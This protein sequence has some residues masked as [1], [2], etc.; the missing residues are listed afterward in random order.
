M[1]FIHLFQVDKNCNNTPQD[2]EGA[3]NNINSCNQNHSPKRSSV[4]RCGTANVDHQSSLQLAQQPIITYTQTAILLPNNLMQPSQQSGINSEDF[5][6]Q[7]YNNHFSGLKYIQE[8]CQDP[9]KSSGVN[10]NYSTTPLN[11]TVSA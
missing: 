6:E 2:V 4:L 1:K 5:N 11:K 8:H 9:L 3:L 10:H 7:H